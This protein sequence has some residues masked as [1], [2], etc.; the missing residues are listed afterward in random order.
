MSLA[1]ETRGL[2]KRFGDT[3]AVSRLDLQIPSGQIFGLLGPNGSGKTTTLRLLLGLIVPT[4]GLAS[5]LGYS[6]QDEPQAIRAHAGALLEHDGLY[7]RFSAYDNLDYF[8]RIYHI[9][10][11]ER[12]RRIERLLR[13]IGLWD[14]R[15]DP[16][17]KWSKGMRQ[18]LAI[19]R[20]LIHEPEIVFLDEP[21]SGL[22]PAA[23]RSV[24]ETIQRTVEER[25]RTFFICTH[26]LDEAE[27]LCSLVGVLNRG[28][29]VACDTPAGL[30]Q[31]QAR[32]RIALGCRGLSDAVLDQ[33]NALPFVRQA[34][35]QGGR[36]WVDLEDAASIS[37]VVKALVYAGVDVEEVRR[38][39]ESLEEAFLALVEQD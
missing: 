5:V 3:V 10:P 7:D 17:S 4:E 29:L 11:Q 28:T 38:S 39:Q 37:Q 1:V 31:V 9:E 35:M 2:T 23:A 22:D 24:R 26:R 6:A 18:R 30:T 14:R 13:E 12:R 36:L 8:G 34:Q 20:A 27:R 25:Q 21:T 19:A 16:V 32:P 15:A 33:I